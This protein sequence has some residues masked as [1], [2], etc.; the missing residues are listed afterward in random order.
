[1]ID[2]VIIIVSFNT[3][4]HLEAC[5][6]SIH[7]SNS[8]VHYEIIV[9]DNA[10]TDG[11]VEAVRLN[12]PSVRVIEMS[13]NLGYARANN[14]AIRSTNS[15]LILLLN[16]DTIISEGSIDGLVQELRANP[17]T[18]IVGPRLIDASGKNELSFGHMIGPLNEVRQKLLRLTLACNIPLLSNR[19]TR[20]VIKRHS[21]DWVSGACLLV[22]RSDAES[23]G[24]LDE[25]FF[26]YGEDVDFCASVRQLGRRL[27]FVPEIEVVHYRGRSGATTPAATHT[28][29][30]RSQLAFY[31]KHHPTWLPV[32][33]LYLRLKGSLPEEQKRTSSDRIL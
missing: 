28:A 21:P 22:R 25:R 4:A 12:W 16:G 10:S 32:L 15:E 29:Y 24:L 20:A 17:D 26:L 19:I 23:A 30:R 1:M 33:R 31:A 7:A 6:Q 5:L 2:V 14:I 11:S 13:E 8:S 18:A 3:R 9:V 27:L